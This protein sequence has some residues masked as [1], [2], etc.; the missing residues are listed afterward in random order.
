MIGA[1]LMMCMCA[2][3][4]IVGACMVNGSVAMAAFIIITQCTMNITGT[5]VMMYNIQCIIII[6]FQ[7]HYE[8]L[9]IGS[10]H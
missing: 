5:I 3:P 1:C 6:A 7:K 8:H 2:A 9:A 10:K 4:P